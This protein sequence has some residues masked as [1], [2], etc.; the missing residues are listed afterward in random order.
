MWAEASIWIEV[1]ERVL[2]HCTE[3]G[4]VHFTEFGVCSAGII[5]WAKDSPHN[6]FVWTKPSKK[7]LSEGIPAV[8]I[9]VYAV[10]SYL[11]ASPKPTC[12]GKP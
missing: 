4:E 10:S 8:D 7:D 9:A 6:M 3:G 1:D 5:T 12:E 2:A 11:E